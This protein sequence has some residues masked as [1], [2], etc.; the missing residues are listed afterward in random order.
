MRNKIAKLIKA[1]GKP[2]KEEIQK[3]KKYFSKSL[4]QQYQK[5]QYYEFNKQ[6]GV[7][8]FVFDEVKPQ[9]LEKHSYMAHYPY[10]YVLFVGYMKPQH[11]TFRDKG[12]RDSLLRNHVVNQIN[13]QKRLKQRKEQRMKQKKQFKHDFK[14]GDILYSSWGYD[15]TNI[16]FYLVTR[17]ISDKSV[18]ICQIGKK[19]LGSNGYGEDK[20]VADKNRIIG[21][22]MRKVVSKGNYIKLSSF[23]YAHK[24]DGKPCS[25][26]SAGW[27][28]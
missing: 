20:V 6:F 5:V 2:S 21:N 1:Y 7:Y 17:V 11:N 28:H 8:A 3:Y 25:E 9:E 24:W 19:N 27:G 16:D 26:T 14:Q 10:G 4:K 23:E 18:Q 13:N 15:Q 12:R 22:K